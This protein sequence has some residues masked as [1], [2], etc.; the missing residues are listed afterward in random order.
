MEDHG[1]A[2][3]NGIPLKGFTDGLFGEAEMFSWF[4]EDQ[5]DPGHV[6]DDIFLDLVEPVVEGPVFQLLELP[7]EVVVNICRFL[8][9]KSLCRLSCVCWDAHD[10][11]VDNRV[12]KERFDAE[13]RR[14]N[15]DLP[16]QA[17]A[18]KLRVLHERTAA[19]GDPRNPSLRGGVW[20]HV[21]SD[22]VRGQLGLSDEQQRVLQVVAEGR[23]LFM[24]GCGGTGKSHVLGLIRGLLDKRGTEYAL[25]ATTGMAAFGIGGQTLHSWAG[26]RT[27]RNATGSERAEY[28]TGS[29]W[30]YKDSWRRV[31]VLIIDEVSMLDADYFD[32]LNRLAKVIRD[33]PRGL[34]DDLPF[35][36]IQLVMSGDF[37]QLPPVSR[38]R[39]KFCFETESWAE[40]ISRN[41]VTVELATVFRQEDRDFVD[42]LNHVRLGSCPP[43]ITEVLRTCERPLEV[44]DG[45][46]PTMLYCNNEMVDRFNESE[47]ER[48]TG[49]L[50]TYHSLDRVT[51]TALVNS[52][53]VAR[54]EQALA[55]MLES[56][57]AAP[58]IGVKFNAQV[59]LTKNHSAHLVNGSRGVVVGF[60]PLSTLGELI[61]TITDHQ[62]YLTEWGTIN[63]NIR[64]PVVKF[65][66]GRTLAC[67]PEVFSVSTL[68]G[69]A[70]RVQIPLRLAWALTVHKAQGLSL[71]KAE[72]SLKRAF[73]CGQ[74]YVALSR[75]KSLRGLQL[76]DFS[77]AA[78]SADLRVLR[79][80]HG[81]F[82]PPYPAIPLPHTSP[83]K[84]AGA[85]HSPVKPSPDGTPRTPPS[86]PQSPDAS[87]ANVF[88]SG[89]QL[90]TS[91]LR[92][93][94]DRLQGKLAR[95]LTDAERA[96]ID[97]KRS[98]AIAVRDMRARQRE[99]EERAKR[100]RLSNAT[101]P[102]NGRE[103]LVDCA[104]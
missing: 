42:L 85:Q 70:V 38:G 50:C 40:C 58:T 14:L 59:M 53:S 5:P 39:R 27:T 26:V 9:D 99:H 4:F 20:K 37:L 69:H 44:A 72:I 66:N 65:F 23:H 63:A 88:R 17:P 90:G 96:R 21:Y 47:L 74:A 12:W 29:A 41:G 3:P 18:W 35:G 81:L 80:Y 2:D 62:L 48:L 54:A 100:A 83:G 56:A 76:R 8:D 25:T 78:I 102:I 22:F 87:Q 104:D 30:R 84:P 32:E 64:V 55:H 1:K 82:G 7:F 98:A 92:A 43:E 13:A 61:A 10:A 60:T 73:A 75:V 51:V 46:R 79:F 6:P 57:P 52:T 36:G 15:P 49:D 89:T 16:Q 86:T 95:E 94:A 71:D 31:Q 97:R 93:L 91:P 68:H 34:Q 19:G 28:D 67:G 11:S 24:T 77:P 103:T 45:I 33:R 101:E